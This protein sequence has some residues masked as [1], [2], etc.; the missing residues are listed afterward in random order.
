M[1]ITSLNQVNCDIAVGQRHGIAG[2]ARQLWERWKHVARKIG[3][4]QARA[5]MTVFYFLILGPVSLGLRWRNDPLAIK[6][7]TPRG[8]NNVEQ[9]GGAPMEHSRR[10]F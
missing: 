6:P 5:L 4:F 9:R 2:S 3:D 8:W 1:E 10:Q 7:T